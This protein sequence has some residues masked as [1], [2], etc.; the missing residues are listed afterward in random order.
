RPK[1]QHE[2]LVEIAGLPEGRIIVAREGDLVAGYVTS[3]YPDETERWYQAGTD[4]LIELGAIGVADE[5]RNTGLGKAPIK[6]AFENGQL[7]NMIV[8]TTEYYWHWDL[9]GSGLSV[10]E[11]REMM[12]RLM[13]VV[14]MEW[15]ATDDPEI[16]AH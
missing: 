11:Y 14:G 5:Y 2:A 16:C 6:T 3:H 4:D 13:K 12:E 15:F 9:E 10:C 7:D 8:Y 1:A